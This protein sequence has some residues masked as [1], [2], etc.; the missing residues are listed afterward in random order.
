VKKAILIVD[1]HPMFRRGLVSMI[2][3]E[4]DLAVCGEAS[5]CRSALH[6]I[7]QSKP[8]L[9]IVDLR[10]EGGDDGLD[11]IK[12]M[13]KYHPQIPV[14]ALSMHDEAVYAERS[15]RAGAHGYITKQQLDKTVL[16]A[17]RNLL[18][19]STYMSDKLRERLVAKFVSGQ[20]LETDSPLTVLSDREL[21]VFR[22]IGQGRTTRLIAEALHLSI[23]TIESHREHIKQKLNLAS[24]AELAQRA[25]Q[26]VETGRIE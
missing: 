15:L 7:Q 24:S 17:I 2:E 26:W 22:L 1:D 21:Q 3:S 9:V 25:T 13:K 5:T 6:A 23:K 4:A 18:A 10:L 19:G 20:T 14:L 11:L 16:F 12:D 8:D